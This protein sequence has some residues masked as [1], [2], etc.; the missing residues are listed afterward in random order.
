MPTAYHELYTLIKGADPTARLA[1]G[2]VIQATPLRLEYLTK[3]WNEY[4]AAVR[5]DAGGCLECTQLYLRG[6]HQ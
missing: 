2:G 3:V 1:I 4:R 5:T 6:R